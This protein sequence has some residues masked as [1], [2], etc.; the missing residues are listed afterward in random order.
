MRK[1]CKKVFLMLCMLSLVLVSST[2][3]M[4]AGNSKK[5]TLN[6]SQYTLKQGKSIT[7]KATQGSKKVKISDLTFTSSNKKIA[8]VTSK[9]R[10]TGKKKGTAKITVKV[11]ST[12][13]KAVCKITVGQPVTRVSVKAK[14]V[15]LTVG[16]TSTI[17]TTVSPAK[18]SNK[19]VIYKSSNASVVTVSS[20]G[21]LTA[22]KAGNAT[23]TVTAKD[24]SKKK[25]TVKVTVKNKPQPTKAPTQKPENTATPT[26]TQVPKLS[27]IGI[28]LV[29]KDEA[30][31]ELTATTLEAGTTAQVKVESLVPKGLDLDNLTYKSSDEKVASVDDKGV[32]TAIKNG[33]FSITVTAEDKWGNK[34]E[35]TADFVVGTHVKSIEL[36]ATE[37]TL[38]Q[39]E[40]YQIKANILPATANTRAVTYASDNEEVAGISASGLITANAP[41]TANITATTVDGNLRATCALTV[42]QQAE[43]TT[44]ATQEELNEALTKE[45]THNIKLVTEQEATINIPQGT[46]ENVTLTINAPKAHIENEAV[47]KSIRI[48]AIGTNTFVEKA[49]GNAIYYGAQQGTVRVEESAN[50]ALYLIPGADKLSLINNGNVS[51]VTLNTKAEL[52]VSGNSTSAIE[53]NASALAAG[54]DITTGKKLQV[55]AQ[56]VITLKI[57]SGGEETEV[58]VDSQENIPDIYG[59]GRIYVEIQITARV[60]YIVGKNTGNTEDAAKRNVTGKVMVD[61]STPMSG[62]DVYLIPFIGEEYDIISASYHATTDEN[63]VYSVEQV[64]VGNYHLVVMAKGYQP[65]QETFV[66]TDEGSE[67]YNAET[68]YLIKEGETATGS[69]SGT[70]YNAQDGKPVTAGITVRIRNGKNNISGDYLKETVTD[71]NG[72][73]AFDNLLAGQYTVQVIDNRENSEEKYVDA[74]FNAVVLANQNNEK[75]STITAT[76]GTDQVR[77]VL[78]WGDEASGASR[79]LDSHLV[80]PAHNTIGEFH[81]WFGDQRYGVYEGEKSSYLQ[82]ADLDVDDTTWE[83]PETSTIYTKETGEYRFYIHDYSNMNL[84]DCDQMGKSNATVEVYVGNRLKATYY[85]PNE[86]GTLWYVCKYNAIEDTL[87]SVNTMSYW[88]GATSEIGMDLVLLRKQELNQF[89]LKA[90]DILAKVTEEQCKQELAKSIE[91]AEVILK[92]S[93]Q[94]EEIA[95]MDEKLEELVN[96]YMRS[97]T[98]QDITGEDVL[99]YNINQDAN[100]CTIYGVTKKLPDYQVKVSENSSY[101]IRTLT[102]GDYPQ[103]IAVTGKGGYTYNYNVVYT[104]DEET[105][106]GVSSVSSES[107]KAL[108]YSTEYNSETDQHILRIWGY[109]LTI[110]GDLQIVLRGDKSQYKLEDTG[111]EGY[112]KKLTVTYKEESRVYNVSYELSEDA[113][114]V[115]RVTDGEN[116]ILQW[117]ER[118]NWDDTVNDEICYLDITGSSDSLSKEFKVE[119]NCDKTQIQ[120]AESDKEGYVSKVIITYAGR[121]K[122]YYVKYHKETEK[123]YV[124][125]IKDKGNYNFQ[126]KIDYEWNRI[127]A[128]GLLPQPSEQ[129]ELVVSQGCTYQID[130][131]TIRLT[132]AAGNMQ[133]YQL[134]YE[135]DYQCITPVAV[136]EEGNK[137]TKVEWNYRSLAIYGT[138]KALSDKAVFQM[139]EDVEASY[140]AEENKLSVSVPTISYTKVFDIYYYVDESAVTISGYTDENNLFAE[141]MCYVSSDSIT[142]YGRN[143]ELGDTIQFTVP[144]GAEVSSPVKREERSYTATVTNGTQTKEYNIYY[145]Q[146]AKYFKILDITTPDSPVNYKNFTDDYDNRG[147]INIKGNTEEIPQNLQVKVPEGLTAQVVYAKEDENGSYSFE[148]G[149]TRDYPAKIVVTNQGATYSYYITYSIDMTA[150]TVTGFE[151][152]NNVLNQEKSGVYEKSMV[153]YG[154]NN[155]LGTTI[156]FTVP[157]GT[158]VTGPVKEENGSGYTITVT[159]GTLTKE[160]YIEYYQDA[161][162]FPVVKIT[163]NGQEISFEKNGYNWGKYGYIDITGNTM[164]LPTGLQ[165]ETAEGLTAKMVYA[166]KDEDGNYVFEDGDTNNYPAKVVVTNQ[167]ATYL[168]YVRYEADMDKVSIQDYTDENNVFNLAQGYLGVEKIY[169]YGRNNQLGDTIVF[170]VPEG[171]QVSKPE[172]QEDGTYKVTVTKESLFKEYIIYYYQDVQQFEID[173]VKDE[174]NNI[175]YQK[176]AYSG[177][178]CGYIYITGSNAELGD[179][180]QV[181][182]PE[183]LTAQVIYGEK[184]EAGEYS[185]GDGDTNNYPAKVVVTNQGATYTYYVSYTLQ[186]A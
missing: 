71:D 39:G 77:F 41:G 12:K 57:L 164:E 22:K 13:K 87:T 2:E 33:E 148:D 138:N 127:T 134:D 113:L 176:V 89:I 104:Y 139:P 95:Q 66:L 6:Y 14:K 26:P 24:G 143:N 70:L 59:M 125:S 15:T 92:D 3:A 175:T 150:V 116:A 51:S 36:S 82:C 50:T 96:S 17:K 76:L 162:Q 75:N 38:A 159:N 133:E 97:V 119:T 155:E 121:E 182:V 183:G 126:A 108:R 118:W 1:Q 171:A 18:A 130:G 72:R 161:E 109:S 102:E 25:A 55:N 62:A 165:V 100:E 169:I 54:S 79:D 154:R 123:P 144:E 10:V 107:D 48:E 56:A 47:F 42:T 29:Q 16:D 110:P 40:V 28:T 88:T 145:Y 105:M 137:I 178:P 23:I 156:K 73:Y 122:V 158:E 98:I 64:M 135:E 168:Y 94:A 81:T 131:S 85:V 9:G 20:K 44:V 111:A 53:V 93:D 142:L 177:D 185:F 128:T 180:L 8:T 21:K 83:G 30:G 86:P 152:E 91:E 141:D 103:V 63:G 84:L 153:I 11:K 181:E 172:L 149:D 174:N 120:Y 60:E 7:L 179:S 157:E 167:G 45:G 61:N 166:N 35:E 151:D 19:A 5:V 170:H 184:N 117:R 99:S 173:N 124:I 163:D 52:T 147:D 32:V 74:R 27:V 160:Y 69:L 114:N 132:D 80:G 58:S 106:F 101:E 112:V 90:K 115:C 37:L 4:A 68:V 31:N 78:R 49:E 140:D 129:L 65:V 136:T 186:E 46:Y 43:E 146:T 67:V 34:A